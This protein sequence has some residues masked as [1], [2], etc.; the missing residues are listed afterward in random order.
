MIPFTILNDPSTGDI[1]LSQGLRFTADLATYAV[2]RLDENLSFF[3]GEWFLDT[4][5]GV[6]YWERIIGA[7]PDLGLIDTLY[8]RAILLT[9]SV[10]S[11]P[12][13][14]LAFDRS[15]RKLAP[16]FNVILKDGSLI[17]EADLGRKFLVDV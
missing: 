1:D 6:P 11:V 2:Q 8:R 9:P 4:R 15:T 10:G 7:K 17:T 3:L 13:L 14:K 5:E 12:N 16:S